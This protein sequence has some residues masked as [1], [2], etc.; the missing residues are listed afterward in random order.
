MFENLTD[1]KRTELAKVKL[2]NLVGH[3]VYLIALHEINAIVVYS[4]KLSEQIP[5]SYAANAFNLFREAM[6]QI[7][8]VR[9]CALWDK[10]D[11]DNL[12]R[13]PYTLSELRELHEAILGRRLMRDSFNR[14]VQPLL[15]PQ[16]DGDGN[17]VTRVAGG[18]PARLF[19]KEAPPTATFGWRL[20]SADPPAF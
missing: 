20:P 4:K 18:R 16:T 19:A 5:R 10:P 11:P 14:R 15:A 8:I 1:Q 9:L 2:E 17:P 6:H 3:F 12:L 13:E 7:E